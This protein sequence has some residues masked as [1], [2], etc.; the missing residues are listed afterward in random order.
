[1]FVER[2]KKIILVGLNS[3]NKLDEL[4]TREQKEREEKTRQ[5]PQLLV[6]TGEISAPADTPQ[7]YLLVDLSSPFDNPD[8]VVSFANYNLSDSL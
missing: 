8:F 5:E 2:E 7:V 6:S 4:E 1:L 3:I